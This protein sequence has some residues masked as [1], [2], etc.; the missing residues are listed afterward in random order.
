MAQRRMVHLWQFIMILQKEERRN[1][2]GKT[3]EL[4]KAEHYQHL[5]ACLQKGI[6]NN[7]HYFPYPHRNTRR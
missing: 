7:R 5:H 4:W 3:A 2:R 6:T 1:V